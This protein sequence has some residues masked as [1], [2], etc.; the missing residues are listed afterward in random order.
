MHIADSEI[1]K[2]TREF[3]AAL[4][5]GQIMSPEML[6][7]VRNLELIYDNFKYKLSVVGIAPTKYAVILN[8][9]FIEVDVRRLTGLMSQPYK[10]PCDIT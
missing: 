2:A 6:K 4:T 1:A 5:R 7:K 8:N 3:C 9:S 10:C